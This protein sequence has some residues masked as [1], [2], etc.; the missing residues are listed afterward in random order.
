MRPT[1]PQQIGISYYQASLVSELIER[2]FEFQAI[3]DM[4]AGYRDGLS[5]P[6]V[7]EKVLGLTLDAFDTRFDE[8]LAERFDVIAATL[9]LPPEDDATP[10]AVEELAI[11]AEED[12]FDFI[13]QLETGRR[14]LEEGDAEKAEKLLERAKKLFPQYA[15]EGNAYLAL[16]KIHRDRGDIDR[17][18]Q[19]LAT[20][21]DINES[22]YD[23]HVMLAG[24]YWMSVYPGLLLLVLVFSVNIVG[25]R[26]REILNPRLAQ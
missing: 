12:P 1:Y 3:R 8:Y 21:V 4:L 9:R 11:R 25:D 18:A 7:F 16:A 5:T 17:A 19:E 2:D 20:F 10:D 26:L 13:A 6:E 23:A 15:G 24:L 14:A 22:H